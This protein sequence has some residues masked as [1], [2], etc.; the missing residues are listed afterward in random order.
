MKLTKNLV[1]LILTSCI[2][3][4]GLADEPNSPRP[5]PLT[6]PLLKQWLESVKQRTPRIP[7]PELSALD[8]EA[9]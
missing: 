4:I 5:T 3:G 2:A 1:L 9:L 7:L 6:R 8:R